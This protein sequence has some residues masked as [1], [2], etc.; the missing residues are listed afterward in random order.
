VRV[1][2]TLR[3]TNI[4]GPGACVSNTSNAV[5]VPVDRWIR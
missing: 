5:F 1:N 3:G 2:H 4:H